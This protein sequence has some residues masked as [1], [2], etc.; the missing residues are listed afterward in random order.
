[1]A[2]LM[3]SDRKQV[4][5]WN[6]SM[7]GE[8]LHADPR[9]VEMRSQGT[10]LPG[11]TCLEKQPFRACLFYFPSKEMEIGRNQGRGYRLRFGES[12]LLIKSWNQEKL[13][14]F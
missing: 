2:K 4:V 11:K 9:V 14:L 3:G 10:Q 12:E 6:A 7:C 1:M 5:I 8:W 13:P